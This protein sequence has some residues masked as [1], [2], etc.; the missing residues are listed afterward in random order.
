M[1]GGEKCVSHSSV[2]PWTRRREQSSGRELG[3]LPTSTSR[4]LWHSGGN[5]FILSEYWW[6]R[7]LKYLHCCLSDHFHFNVSG[8]SKALCDSPSSSLFGP[9]SPRETPPTSG[10][11]TGCSRSSDTAGKSSWTETRCG[12]T[13]GPPPSL[14]LTPVKEEV[15]G[16]HGS[17]L[18]AG[19]KSSSLQDVLVAW[20]MEMRGASYDSCT[21]DVSLARG[22]VGTAMSSPNTVL[23]MNCT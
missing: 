17:L 7:C 13:A 5:R 11:N 10:Q 19:S 3:K 4:S 14:R 12:K 9:S 16:K 6:C 1:G 23:Y 2:H 8:P 15:E 20:L 21:L 22:L 18:A